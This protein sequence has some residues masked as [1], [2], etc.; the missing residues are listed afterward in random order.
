MGCS[1]TMGKPNAD[2]SC[3]VLLQLL[4]SVQTPLHEFITTVQSCHL[5][6]PVHRGVLST[7]IAVSVVEISHQLRK[8]STS[9][10]SHESWVSRTLGHSLTY[11]ACLV[12]RMCVFCHLHGYQ[13]FQLSCYP[14]GPPCPGPMHAGNLNQYLPPALLLATDFISVYA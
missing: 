13:G 6:M 11:P 10:R 14:S 2:G 5:D 8:V 7:L 12:T 1:G 3:H 4:Y 9:P